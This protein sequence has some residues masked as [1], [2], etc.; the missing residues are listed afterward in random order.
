[1][2]CLFLRVA[3]AIGIRLNLMSG[4][5]AKA[6]Q[7]CDCGEDAGDDKHRDIS[8]SINERPHDISG[9]TIIIPLEKRPI[10]QD[11]RNRK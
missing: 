7:N 4:Q 6:K 11:R 3:I 10:K 1:M 2:A 5:E 8:K 9:K